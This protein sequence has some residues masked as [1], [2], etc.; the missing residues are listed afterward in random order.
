MYLLFLIE[1]SY[2]NVKK[3]KYKERKMWKM[4]NRKRAYKPEILL[5]VTK[6][7]Y[8]GICIKPTKILEKLEFKILTQKG[9]EGKMKQSI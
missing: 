6:N 2:I 5:S 4:W 7:E 1:V 9:T 3:V 8:S